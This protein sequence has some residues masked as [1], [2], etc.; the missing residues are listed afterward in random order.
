[1]G[2]WMPRRT[3]AFARHISFADLL[4]HDTSPDPAWIVFDL[5]HTDQLR[6]GGADKRR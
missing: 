6:P 5:P 3:E 2:K 1:M 4:R